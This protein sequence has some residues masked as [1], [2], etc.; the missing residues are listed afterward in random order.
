MTQK[1]DL[2][3]DNHT[4]EYVQSNIDDFIPKEEVDNFSA[5]QQNSQQEIIVNTKLEDENLKQIQD[6]TIMLQKKKLDEVEQSVSKRNS[7]KNKIL[8]I[9]FFIV[10]VV[11]VAGILI[12]QLLK[13]DIQAI[14]GRFDI[15]SIFVIVALLG[16][17]IFSE[18]AAISYLLKISTG[19]WRFG[20]AYKVSQLGK[21]YDS[22]TPM[23]TGGQP[24]QITYLKSH[25]TPIHTSLSIPL[26]KYV[27]SQIAWVITSFVCLVISWRNKTYGTFISVASVLGFVFSSIM[28]FVVLF[29]SICKTIGKR[30]VV[31]TLKLLHKMK[32]IKNYD[33]Q[34]EKITKYISDFQDV[35][36]QY[37]RSPKDFIIMLFLSLAKNFL[38]YSM[39]F[40]IVKFFM[41]DIAGAMYIRM[42]VMTCLVDLSSSFF[43]FPGGTGMN[44]IS[45]SAAFGAVVGK[46]THLAWVLIIWR[47]CS[48]YFYLIQG[49]SILSY[50]FAYGN[51]KYKWEVVRGNLAQESE[52]FKQEQI[53]KFRSERAKRRKS[54]NKSNVREYL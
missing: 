40:F 33:K 47:L 10:N 48:Y 34:Y 45:F 51:R 18:T 42:F 9:I 26:A 54:K 44:E 49:V 16:L 22:V 7:K 30:I 37:A 15:G 2:K 43:P 12:Y 24:F 3:K 27:F 50:D 20:L 11:V 6:Q 4:E 41:P 19:K 39:P 25:G 32:I 53:N 14:R 23:A 38:N 28:L 35:M 31:R 21:Y 1:A 29:L 46:Q 52:L 5:N 13:E 8:N 36:K 17:V